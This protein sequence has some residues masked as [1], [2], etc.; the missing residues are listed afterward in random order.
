MRST[1]HAPR[2][3]LLVFAASGYLALAAPG[4]LAQGVQTYHQKYAL[5]NSRAYI[6]HGTKMA[7]GACRFAGPQPGIRS[8]SSTPR[9]APLMLSRGQSAVEVRESFFDRSNCTATMEQ[10]TP[11]ASALH[12]SALPSN[13]TQQQ[14]RRSLE[15]PASGQAATAA[16]ARTRSHRPRAVAA[17][18]YSAGYLNT[19]YDDPWFIDVNYVHVS[20]GYNYK[21]GCVTAGSEGYNLSWYTSSGW[22]LAGSNWATS[23]TCTLEASSIYALFGNG[24]FCYPNTCYSHYN[25]TSIHG[26]RDGNLYGFWN[27][28]CDGD[29]RCDRLVRTA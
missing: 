10:G 8:T 19:A 16:R 9:P 27:S 29:A 1:L 24:A 13:G 21:Y 20:I 17:D 14:S 22:Y 5:S 7:D 23:N 18:L 3:T 28:W 15:T 2:S 12:A 11:P 4:A 25:R 6:L 26:H